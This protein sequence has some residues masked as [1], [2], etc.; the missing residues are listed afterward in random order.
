MRE[1]MFE[2]KYI[3]TFILISMIGLLLLIRNLMESK[4]RRGMYHNGLEIGAAT[5]IGN[6][7]L[8]EDA[9]DIAS[10]KKGTLTVLADGIGKRRAGQLSGRLVVKIFVDLFTANHSIDNINYF[11]K[12]A[13]NI[14][15]REIL[16]SLEDHQGG[17]SVVCGIIVD[18]L[19][20]YALVGNTMI[21]V[22]RNNELIPLSEGHTV[23]IL[24][25][26][27]FYQGKISRQDALWAL[28]EKRLFNYVGQDGFQDIEI[29][30]VPVKL[31]HGDIILLMSDGIHSYLP[32][33]QLEDVLKKDLTCDEMA[34]TIIKKLKEASIAEK[35]NASIILM[36]Y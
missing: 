32:W 2:N 31:K 7:E 17:A 3:V 36:R 21:A 30:D 5:F 4:L 25:Q 26:K 10:F 27:G 12:R 23:N 1:L 34:T 28:K 14:S 6:R 16:K 24:A 9:M 19:L 8:Q 33:N 15:N 20:H 18:D 22:F 29:Y 11:F 13:F 35:D